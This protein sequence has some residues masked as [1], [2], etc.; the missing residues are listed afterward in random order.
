MASSS[1]VSRPAQ[2]A[3]WV[4][5]VLFALPV[6]VAT[7]PPMADLPLH[8]ASVG[9]LRHWGDPTFAPRSVYFLNL[10]QA[11]QLFS[12]LDFLLSLALP[13]AWASKIVVAASL[14]ALPLA[15]AHFADYLD[16][17]R[18]TALLVAPLGLGWLFFWGL[19]QNTLGIVALLALL[20]SIDRFAAQPTAR[21]AL[22]MC[23]GMVLLHFTHQAMQLVALAAVVLCSAGAPVHDARRT[24]L[25]ASPVV[26][27]VALVAAARLYAQH[28][29]GAAHRAMPMFVW[30]RVSRKLEIVPGVL[31]AG[32]E[33]YVRNL[34]MLLAVVP[35]AIFAVERVR[36]RTRGG[37]GRGSGVHEWRFELLALVLFVAYLS[38]PTAIK[39][40]TLV[41]HRFLPPAWAI[42]AVAGAQRARRIGGLLPPMACA[43]LPMASLLT[44]WPSFVD[45]SRIY[46]DLDALIPKMQRGSAVLPM[47]LGPNNDF[48]LW[49][50]V[51]AAGH[52]V[53]VNG[54]R[55]LND[56]TLSPTSPVAQRPEKQWT[57]PLLR[58]E[59][60]GLKC[61]PAWDFQR[62]RYLLLTTPKP[63]RAAAM[64][65]ALR[66]EASLI[67]TSGDW[68]L[69]ESRLPLL[70]ID[71]DDAP[72]P[73][74][75]P[76][77]L[78]TMANEVLRAAR[79]PLEGEPAGPAPPD[80]AP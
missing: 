76:P 6:L 30:M 59:N 28:V 10:G 46:S 13:I 32:Y 34:L 8:E 75:P 63:T 41:F 54:G 27:C 26:F 43:A 77:T 47:D 21:G 64:T 14:V 2:L 39:S 60:Y 48:R 12:L 57:E 62:F 49:S 7:Y 16:A 73:T 78:R 66:N 3:P 23:A 61:R 35:L 58:M 65:L 4:A 44:A 80:E 74:P 68:Y 29:Q 51:V 70:P 67:A 36:Q 71:A 31:F 1:N 22:R 45:S 79:E 19:I 72:L 50:P 5:G 56:Y 40:T 33:P 24:A 15:A 18:W 53:A 42:L 37:A 20:P 52:V 9:L 11:N 38:A 69:F 17:P 25:R 55:S